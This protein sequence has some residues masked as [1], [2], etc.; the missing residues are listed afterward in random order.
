MLR[1]ENKVVEIDTFCF[2]RLG[3]TT[4]VRLCPKLLEGPRILDA[5]YGESN[6]RAFQ[7]SYGK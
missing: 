6:I 7:F 5:L 2:V 4:D 3:I 1:K